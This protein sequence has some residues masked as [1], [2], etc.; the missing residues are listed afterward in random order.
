MEKVIGR[1]TPKFSSDRGVSGRKEC[2]QF[3][4]DAEK[5]SKFGTDKWLLDIGN[6]EVTDDCSLSSVYSDE[7]AETSLE[8]IKE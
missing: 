6:M 7:G 4:N 2:S 3:L 1:Q 8:Q 5:T